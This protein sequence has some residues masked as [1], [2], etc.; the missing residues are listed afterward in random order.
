MYQIL[1]II[2]ILISSFI[3]ILLWGYSFSYLDDSELN[4]KRFVFW[5]ISGVLSVLPILYMDKINEI[6]KINVLNISMHFSEIS[7][8]SWIFLFF[9]SLLSFVLIFL[10]SSLLFSLISKVKLFW[11]K[12]FIKNSLVI[13]L[14]TFFIALLF[15]LI[16]YIFLLIPSINFAI[17]DSTTF[18]NVSL[19]SFKLVILYYIIVWFLE[20]ISK[21]FNFSWKVLNDISIKRWVLYSIFIALWFSFIENILYLYNLYS[22]KGLSSDLFKIYFFRSIFSVILHVFCTS[23]LSYSFLKSLQFYKEW[24]TFKY[25]KIF[26]FGLFSSIFLHF[27]FDLCLTLWFSFIIIIYLVVWY[28]YVTSIFYK[29]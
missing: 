9:L 12:I 7:N 5:I 26:L 11:Y 2:L 16:D 29:N 20:E 10:L 19:N 8:I 17:L 4:K 27:F 25:I 22:I 23:V 15:Y 6:I 1:I 3:P 13:V 24:K 28:L 14:F 21:Y 18:W